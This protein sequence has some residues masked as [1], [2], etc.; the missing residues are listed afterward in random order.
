MHWLILLSILFVGCG[1]EEIYI[2]EA[3]Q[4]KETRSCKIHC[5]KDQ[6]ICEPMICKPALMCEVD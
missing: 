1:D 3:H 5:D 2:F 6:R 4:C